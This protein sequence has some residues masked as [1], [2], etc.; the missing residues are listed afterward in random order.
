LL[1]DDTLAHHTKCSIEEL[2][3][4]K[5]H[6]LDRYVWPHNVVTSYYLN[7]A[8]QFP[9]DFRLYLQ[10]RK[11]KW[12]EMLADLTESLRGN[13]TLE[14]YRRYLVSL[15]AYDVRRQQ[16]RPKTPLAAELVRQAVAL[17]LPFDVVLFDGWYCRWRRMLTAWS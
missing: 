12:L 4:L 16:Y 13:P 3:H 10:F 14:G 11:K 15:L 8:D 9:V 5:D 2:A 6:T 7:R 1:I 17:G